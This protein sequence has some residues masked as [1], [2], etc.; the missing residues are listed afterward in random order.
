MQ[1]TN[2]QNIFICIF[3]HYK[4]TSKQNCAITLCFR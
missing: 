2:P 3:P 4:I 1:S